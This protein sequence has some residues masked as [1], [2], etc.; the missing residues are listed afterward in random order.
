MRKRTRF[1]LFCFVV[2]V[3]EGLVGLRRTIQVQLLQHY[4]LGHRLGQHCQNVE[5][6]EHNKKDFLLLWIL[7]EAQEGKASYIVPWFLL[8]WTGAEFTYYEA[9]YLEN[10]GESF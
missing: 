3:L 8:F 6:Q 5:E 1:V 9:V 7:C 2:L 4:W 10:K